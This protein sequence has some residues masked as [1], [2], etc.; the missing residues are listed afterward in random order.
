M[1]LLWSSL[2]TRKV[3]LMTRTLQSMSAGAGGRGLGHLRA[4]PDDIGWA[5]TEEDAAAVGRPGS[6]T[7]ASSSTSTPATSRLRSA[8]ASRR[9]RR[10]ATRTSGTAASLAGLEAGD[11]HAVDRLLLLY[12]VAFAYGGLPLIYMGDELGLLNDATG[13][14]TRCTR[15]TTAGC[16]GRRWTGRPRSGR[17]PGHRRGAAVGGLQRLIE[18]RR[19]TRAVHAQGTI[20]AV[21]TGNDHVF[22]LRREPATGLLLANFARAA[23]RRAGRVERRS[24]L[25]VCL[26]GRRA[27]P[28]A[29]PM[30][31]A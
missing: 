22:G 20:E 7:G 30:A 15:A 17:R 3:A 24:G 19:G 2:A 16:T 21:W 14:P 13:P 28:G 31:I 12:A 27:A 9:T 23:D 26:A 5:I 6:S 10:P 4:L 8:R 18:Q 25:R 1:V 11:E 29:A